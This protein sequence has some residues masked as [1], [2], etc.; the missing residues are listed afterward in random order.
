[1]TTTIDSKVVQMAFDN[2]KFEKNVGTSLDSVDKLKKSLNF[3]GVGKSFSQITDSAGK[4]NLSSISDGVETI[5]NKFSTMGIIAI[6]TLVNIVNSAYQTGAKIVKALTVDPISTGLNEYETKLNSVQTILANTQR[7]GT[8]LKVVTDALNQLNEYSDKTIYNFQQMTKNVGTFTAAG[9][10]LDASVAAIKGIANLAA[11][12]GSNAEQAS[13]A[14]YQLSQALSSGTVKLMDWNSVVNAGMG[15]QV[16][17]DAIKETARLHGVAIDQMIEEEGSFRETLQK[18]WFTSEILTETLAKFTGDLNADQLKTMGYTEEQIASIIKMG[19]T[20]NDAATKVKTFTQLFDTLKEAAQSGW[21][22]TWEILIGD[23]EEAK[24][25]LTDLNNWFGGI[26][27]AMADARNNLLQGWK[28]LG[29]R[30]KLLE[31]VK[32]ILNA[33][34]SLINPIKEGFRDIFPPTTVKQLL[35]LT[36][37]FRKFTEKLILSSENSDRIKR[38]FKGLFALLDIG[39]L[40]ISAFVKGLFGLSGGLSKPIDNLVDFLA[41]M[42]DF[43]VKMR[44]GLKSS[45]AFN[46]TVQKIGEFIKPV[47]GFIKEVFTSISNGIDGLKNIKLDGVS[48]FFDNLRTRFEPLT[49]VFNLAQKFI[50][51]IG[52]A[53]QKIGPIFLKL[54]GIISDGASSFIDKIMEAL[55]NFD[56]NQVFDIINGGLLAGILLA[57]R[58]FVNKGSDAFSGIKDV[59]DTVKGSLEAWQ[60]SLKAD[61]LLKIAGALGILTISVVALSMIDSKRLTSALTA[62]SVMFAELGLSLNAFQK[63]SNN[64]NVADMGKLSVGLLSVSSAILIM[65]FAVSKLGK[66]NTEELIKGLLAITGIIFSFKLSAEQLKDSSSKMIVGSAAL[67]VFSVAIRSMTVA[68]KKLGEID[69]ESLAKGLIGIGVL[70]TEISLFLKATDLSG[71]GALK[72][73]GILILAGSIMVLTTAV[74]KLSKID[75][76]AIG[77]GLLAIAAIF[78]E[79]AAFISLTGGASGLIIVSAGVGVLS[80]SMLVMSKV[81]ETMGNMSWDEIARG[82]TNLAGAL[83]IIGAAAYLIPPTLIITAGGMVVMAAALVIL[84]NAMVKMGGMS[85]DEIGRGL[86]VLASSLLILTVALTAMSGTVVGSAALLIAAGALAILAPALKTMGSISMKEIG[87]GLLSLAGTFVVLGVAA[88]VLTP[89]IPSLLSLGAALLLI[90]IGATGIGAGLLAFSAGLAALAVSG[91]AGAAALV[92]VLTSIIGLIPM[93]IKQL[94]IALL[95]LVNVLVA[96]APTLLKGIVTLIGILI[97]GIVELLP[98]LTDGLLTIL[99]SLLS[100]LA[101]NTP[102]FVKAGYE[103]VISLLKGLKKNVKTI[104]KLS[105]TIIKEFI[106]G[107]SDRLDDIVDSG[108]DLITAFIDAMADSAED[109][110][111]DIMKSVR[112]LGLSIVKGVIKGITDSI[113]D[114]KKAI[115]D[116]AAQMIAAFKDIFG[117]RSPSTVMFSIATDVVLGFINGIIAKVKDVINTVK[118]MIDS[119]MTTITQRLSDFYKRGV[120]VVTNI[121]NGIIN[122]V[123]LV[124]TAINSLIAQIMLKIGEK[125]TQFYNAGK[126]F[127]DGLKNGIADYIWK[128]VAIAQNLAQEVIDAIRDWFNSHSESKVT[129]QIGNDLVLGLTNGIQ[130]SSKKAI[131]MTKNLAREIVYSFSD[132][133]SDIAKAVE[134]DLTIS[135][136]IRPVIDMTDFNIGNKKIDQALS[137]KF[138]SLD[139]TLSKIPNIK[140]TKETNADSI[141]NTSKETPNS[142]IEFIQNNYSPKE[143]SRLELYRQTRNLLILSKGVPINDQ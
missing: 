110:I 20:A 115:V 87:L 39:R 19:Q 90:G 9:V 78:T 143:L 28:D 125:Y 57:I 113:K 60:N 21:A 32:N 2:D 4:V 5:A 74:E 47:I 117:I 40:T 99:N 107:I 75:D 98:K 48:T 121:K 63:I 44:D 68:V 118:N 85:W 114:G 126:N 130:E 10:K 29:G 104:T 100:G 66:M 82:L 135:P 42:G 89:V 138:I 24:S 31:S 88:S 16:F 137:G 140:T 37:G 35:D 123:Q 61:T 93:I 80:A 132:V 52:K 41:N 72:S 139:S 127:V 86:T 103:I 50:E 142:K 36:E 27:G 79:L 102:K 122:S 25:F 64:I 22:Q 109:H 96:G 14:M 23:F 141:G 83:T 92:I 7:E 116:L 58:K 11:I 134:S 45:D 128:A 71:I 119:I 120:E 51:L 46:K 76:K 3:E 70:L 101:K 34:V 30:T 65:S 124:I 53:L 111:P 106:K 18:G 91:T 38:I 105:I 108:Y 69:T 43:I 6:T 13:T 67:I 17:Q 59:L 133:A 12:S 94:G 62:M 1:M 33:V 26:L 84:G 97:D 15:G 81:L 136:S 55:D 49:K 112:N 8:T 95:A 54:G 129:H 77:K 73:V 131:S 56:P